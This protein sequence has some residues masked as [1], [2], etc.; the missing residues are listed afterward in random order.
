MTAFT[1]IDLSR[2]AP[3]DAIE[4]LDFETILQAMRDDLIARDPSLAEVL[5]LES[6]PINKLLEVCAYR[7]LLVRQRVNDAIRAVLLATATGSNLDHLGTL[8]GVTRQLVTPGDPNATPPVPDVYE[9][10]DR[11][12]HRIQ[13][14][15]EGFSTAGPMGAYVFWGLS[16]DPNVRD[17][18]V[19]SPNPGQVVVTVLSVQ[20]DGTPDQTLLDAVTATLNAEDVRPLT[21]QVTV[22]AA[23]IIT[24]QVQATLTLYY[25]PDAETVRQAAVDAVTRYTQDHHRLGHDITLSGLYAALHVDGVQRVQLTQPTADIV[26]TPEEA[27][28]CTAINVTVGGRDA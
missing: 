3:P 5:A 16:A 2:L 10:D 6:E 17:I 12:R 20:G 18:A 24:Y 8:F 7:E 4:P 25:G 26:V 13:L 15:L 14:A 19:D 23:Q 28:Y 27:A 22:Q 9:D 11:F 21:D 1:A